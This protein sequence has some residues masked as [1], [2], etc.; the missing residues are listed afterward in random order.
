MSEFLQLL[1][2]YDIVTILTIAIL[3]I[4]GIYK[5][6]VWSKKTWAQREVFKKENI[7]KGVEI[8]RQKD[9]ELEAEQEEETRLQRLESAIEALAL[10]NEEQQK[11][12]ALLIESD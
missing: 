10:V 11:H 6:I 8:Q 1:A 9:K 3:V 7:E 2:T 12:I 4:V 5:L